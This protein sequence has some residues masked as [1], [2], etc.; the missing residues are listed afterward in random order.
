MMQRID[1]LQLGQKI[2]R[3]SYRYAQRCLHDRVTVVGGYLAYISLLSL[4]PL[5][6]VMFSMVSAF[7]IFAEFRGDIENFIFSNVIPSRGDEI[8][9][10]ITQFIGNTGKMTAIGLL[11]LIGVALLLIHSID[12]TLNHIWR[13]TK[14]PRL[15]ISFSIYW[16][17]LTL[18]PILFGSSIAVSS[19]LV[20][21]TKFADDYTPG[22]STF[23]LGLTPSLMSL[24][25]FWILYNVVPNVKVRIK[26][27]FWGALLATVL[28]ELSKRGFALYITHFP[29][30]QTL[31]GALALVPILLLWIYMC[32]LVVLLGAELTAFLQE[33]RET[34]PEEDETA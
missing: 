4:V 3:F 18:G 29:T 24:I 33:Q 34:P 14:R 13:V 19:Y 21:L 16:M 12:K 2:A 8:Q 28:F 31:Y 22:V 15:F 7:P 20:S 10:Y 30:Y 23:L 6:A 9:T 32:W 27:A 1:W 17:I 11:A 5:I 25:A 26:D